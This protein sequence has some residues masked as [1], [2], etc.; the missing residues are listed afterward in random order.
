LV[1]SHASL[2][3]F[4][5][6]SVHCCIISRLCI[7][8]V[9]NFICYAIKLCLHDTTLL[10]KEGLQYSLVLNISSFH[11]SYTKM[12]QNVDMQKKCT[13][14]YDIFV[15]INERPSAL[16]ITTFRFV[17]SQKL[18]NFNISSQKILKDW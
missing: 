6:I 17:P 13:N 3:F 11:T 9:H 2:L 15:Q 12:L 7:V 14:D 5:N 4:A 8:F 16:E 1:L 18:L 10:L